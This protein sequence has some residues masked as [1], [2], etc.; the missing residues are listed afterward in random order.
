MT[1]KYISRSPLTNKN[2]ARDLVMKEMKE[3]GEVWEK[4][5]SNNNLFLRWVNERLFNKGKWMAFLYFRFK[6]VY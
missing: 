2:K 4:V 3:L 5:F 6:Q 1:L